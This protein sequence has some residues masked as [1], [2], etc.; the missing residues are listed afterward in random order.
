MYVKY[1]TYNVCVIRYEMDY[2]LA[3][4]GNQV[5]TKK[6]L[7]PRVRGEGLLLVSRTQRLTSSS[8]LKMKVRRPSFMHTY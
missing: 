2:L 1:I 5:R 7:S 4:F 8:D 3:Y 6:T